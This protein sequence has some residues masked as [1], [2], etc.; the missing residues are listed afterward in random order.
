[1]KKFVS[2]TEKLL[3]AIEAYLMDAL[4]SA[5][6]SWN[7]SD[8]TLCLPKIMACHHGY[9]EPIN[10]LSYYPA[11]ILI[12]NGRESGDAFFAQYD[13]TI[14]LAIKCDDN[15]ALVRWGEAYEDILE[16]EIDSDHSLGG[17]VLDVND[18]R[19]D[20]D[21]QSGTYLITLSMTADVD[22][23]GYVYAENNYSDS[24]EA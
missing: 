6:D 22:R 1:M 19:M 16:D 5:C 15:A 3:N 24:E 11:M 12:V 4:S 18:Q 10:G 14:G 13:L 2:R 23:G 8:P 21:L 20:K 7:A 9:C 17:A